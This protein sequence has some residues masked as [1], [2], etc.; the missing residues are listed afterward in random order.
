MKVLKCWNNTSQQFN[1]QY[2]TTLQ[3]CE[4]LLIG[5]SSST[6]VEGASI[7]VKADQY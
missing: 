5:S 7:C 6:V 2:D 3:Y 1:L 4:I